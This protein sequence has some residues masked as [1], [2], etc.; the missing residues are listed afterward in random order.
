[1][2]NSAVV[3]GFN[4]RTEN[5]AATTAKRETV[6]IKLFSI[7][8]ELIDQVR[9]AMAGLLEPLSREAVIGSALCKKVIGLSKYNV[10][11]CAVV[12]FSG[13][14]AARLMQ[15]E[16]TGAPPVAAKADEP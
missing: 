7:I 6:Q 8:Y 16:E 11:G 4:T 15:A 10:A 2:I 13:V 14:V 12:I 3:I 1:M 5:T 9:E